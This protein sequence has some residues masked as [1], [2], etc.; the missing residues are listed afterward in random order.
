MPAPPS[1][2]G[3]PSLIENAVRNLIEN[4]IRHTPRRTAI[5][6]TAGPGPRVSVSDDAGLLRQEP[7]P[8]MLG[9]G[10]PDPSGIGLEIVRRIMKLHRGTLEMSVERGSRT[11]MELA[12]VTDR[13]RDG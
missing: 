4:A 7:G 2:E 5:E 10:S 13:D 1:V 12:F 8:G 11:T 3:H 6:V 9:D